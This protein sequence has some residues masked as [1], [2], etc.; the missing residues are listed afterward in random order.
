M[1]FFISCS[2]T[3]PR[4]NNADV[5]C[6]N[7][8]RSFPAQCLP[9]VWLGMSAFVNWDLN[10]ESPPTVHRTIISPTMLAASRRR[11]CMYIISFQAF[12]SICRFL[13]CNGI[14]C[15]KT[16]GPGQ[17]DRLNQQS[18]QARTQRKHTT[19]QR[20]SAVTRVLCGR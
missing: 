4:P 1:L 2:V 15:Y 6:S 13:A 20:R 17:V 9:V 19:R 18:K 12:I 8:V 11:I 5:L 3:D 16:C 10:I 14:V 7:R